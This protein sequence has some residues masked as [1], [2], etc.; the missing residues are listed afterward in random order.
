[1]IKQRESLSMAEIGQY[2]KDNE[3]VSE[4]N[5]FI[6][7]FSKLNL[8]KAKELR[9]E[10]QSLDLMKLKSDQISKIIDILPEDGEDLNKIFTDVSL[11]EDEIQKI[12]N[13]VKKINK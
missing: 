9:K 5:K 11:D 10:L 7:K 1:M 8:K 13:T 6:K 2:T 12:L 3:N 4:L